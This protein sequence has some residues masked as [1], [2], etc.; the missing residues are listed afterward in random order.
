M[1][2]ILLDTDDASAR[3]TLAERALS[4]TSGGS[5]VEELADEGRALRKLSLIHI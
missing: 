2:D 4:A 3:I 1:W 5:S